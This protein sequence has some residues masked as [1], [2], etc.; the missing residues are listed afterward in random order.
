MN[1]GERFI[2][3]F[4]ALIVLSAGLSLATFSY[5]NNNIATQYSAGGNIHGAIN[6]SFTSEPDSLFTGKLDGTYFNE[7]ITLIDLLKANSL[8]EGTDYTCTYVGCDFLYKDSGTIT[9]AV[10][11]ESNP[12]LVAGFKI[13]E[14]GIISIDSIK[15]AVHS[16]REDSCERQILVDVLDK[17]ESFIQSNKNSGE[18]CGD[19]DRG[20]FSDAGESG[21]QSII[22]TNP[23]CEKISLETAPAYRIGAR[24]TNETG[25]G[26]LTMSLQR[27]DEDTFVF[28]NNYCIWNS[29]QQVQTTQDIY[30]DVNYTTPGG[31]YLVCINS[32][33]DESGYKIDREQVNPPFCGSVGGQKPYT[34]DFNIFAQPLEFAAVGTLNINSSIF[35]EQ[36]PEQSELAIYADEYLEEKYQRNCSGEC[37]IP[38]RFT[39]IPQ[40]L[41]FSNARLIYR[42][43][44]GELVEKT[45]LSKLD[46]EKSKITTPKYV[47]LEISHAGF[48][49]PVGSTANK[50]YIYYDGDQ[51]VSKTIAI[52]PSFAFDIY[53]KNVSFGALTNFQAI[54]SANITSSVWKFGD[55]TTKTVLGKIASHRYTTYNPNGYNV[56]VELTRKDGVKAPGSF[57]VSIGSL[58]TSAN[59]LLSEYDIKIANLRKK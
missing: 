44:G 22:G 45:S 29:S 26:K 19:K 37:F 5:K 38:F 6:I 46:V 8:V 12:S 47:N 36:N 27:P 35:S 51:I 49:I 21:D 43:N 42:I 17:N 31:D 57:H 50:L 14:K 30:C 9:S 7:S 25:T 10:L 15:L 23:Y 13:Y 1:K 28:Y 41:T 20:C 2:V 33:S 53:P 40:T 56:E 54:T 18:T 52:A 55:E 48:R 3:I 34:R 11:T 24:I 16:S 59:Q 58:S 39:G 32:D 4:V